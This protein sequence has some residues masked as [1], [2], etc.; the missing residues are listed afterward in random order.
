MPLPSSGRI[1]MSD[2]W[3]EINS[4]SSGSTVIPEPTECDYYFTSR[5]DFDNRI[6]GI[7]IENNQDLSTKTLG[8]S[9]N[10]E[11]MSEM[12]INTQEIIGLPK[13]IVGKNITGLNAFCGYNTWIKN[14]PET[15]LYGCPKL[16]YLSSAFEKTNIETIPAKLFINNPEL[17]DVSYCFYDTYLTNTDG[18]IFDNNPNLYNVANC[19]RNDYNVNTGSLPDVWNKDK[20]PYI[21]SYVADG[22]AIGNEKC[23]NY[24]DCPVSYGGW[25]RIN[26]TSTN[27]TT[28]PDTNGAGLS[29]ELYEKS[30][31][32][33]NDDEWVKIDEYSMISGEIINYSMKLSR[34]DMNYRI[35]CFSNIPRN[36]VFNGEANYNISGYV[37]D[38]LSSSDIHNTNEDIEYKITFIDDHAGGTNRMN[39]SQHNGGGIGLLSEYTT[40]PINPTLPPG[41]YWFG[42]SSKSINTPKSI[43][44]SKPTPPKPISL[45]SAEFRKLAGVPTGPIKMSDFYGKPDNNHSCVFK[46]IP[47]WSDYKTYEKRV[48]VPDGS[49]VGDYTNIDFE[50][51][52][53]DMGWPSRFVNYNTI[54]IYDT[55]GKVLSGMD[56]TSE[57]K[58]PIICENMLDADLIGYEYTIEGTSVSNNDFAFT[59]ERSHTFH[60]WDDIISDLPS[61]WNDT[62]LLIETE[63][64]RNSLRITEQVYLK[65]DTSKKPISFPYTIIDNTEFIIATE[66]DINTNRTFGTMN[67]RRN[68]DYGPDGNTYDEITGLYFNPDTSA[69]KICSSI[70]CEIHSNHGTTMIDLVVNKPDQT[71]VSK[72]YCVIKGLT[73]TGWYEIM[74]GSLNGGA[75]PIIFSVDSGV[76]GA[77]LDY[78]DDGVFVEMVNEVEDYKRFN[79][80]TVEFTNEYTPQ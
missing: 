32:S 46:W 53:T 8:F 74:V 29:L 11:D 45:G 67:S 49:F 66:P 36:Y 10:V 24:D 79:L 38:S 72:K 55:N 41:V 5:Q 19:F 12:F 48:D 14:V 30:I 75:N 62:A 70:Y 39:Q 31:A 80:V 9:D 73:D 21:E 37:D 58:Q 69:N 71:A 34:H 26:I 1:A 7:L 78:P 52:K 17:T 23:T 18:N 63:L 20:F 57:I 60:F 22:Y 25:V 28:T 40:T 27:I 3:R 50:Q 64:L 33:T 56:E 16:G 77:F 59:H 61:Y 6:E 54:T 13:M 68:V 2:I 47:P 42:L 76:V 51:V 15:L 65:N 4:S 44:K 35:K 43:A